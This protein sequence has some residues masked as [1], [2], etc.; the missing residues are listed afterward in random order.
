[1]FILL[2]HFVA[3]IREWTHMSGHT[4]DRDCVSASSIAEEKGLLAVVAM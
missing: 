1:M 4:E 3:K 2:C